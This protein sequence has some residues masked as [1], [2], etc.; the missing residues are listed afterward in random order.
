MYHNNIPFAVTHV[1]ENGYMFWFPT[2][3]KPTMVRI[4]C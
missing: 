2:R 4:T 1:I 3:Q